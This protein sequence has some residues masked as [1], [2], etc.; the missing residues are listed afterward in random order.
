M[1]LDPMQPTVEIYGR[2]VLHRPARFDIRLS[3][4]YEFKAEATSTDAT[5]TRQL[6]VD[7]AVTIHQT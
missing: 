3:V 1:F 2:W 5:P 4:T 6:S 7:M